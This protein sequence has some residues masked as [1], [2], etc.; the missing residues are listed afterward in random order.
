MGWNRGSQL[1]SDII[2]VVYTNVRDNKARTKIY[3][4]LIEAFEDMDCDTL[5]E[6][7][8]V[9]DEYDR[10]YYVRAFMDELSYYDVNMDESTV[11][12]MAKKLFENGHR[13]PAEDAEQAI[14][15]LK[16]DDNSTNS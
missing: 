9:D 14:K 15:E 7:M 10:I 2:D 11:R 13:D 3:S 1:M 6:C 12:Y 5:M 16:N 8:G 4:S